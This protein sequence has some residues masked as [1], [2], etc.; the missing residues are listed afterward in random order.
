MSFSLPD[1]CSEKEPVD[2]QL[3]GVCLGRK[4]TERSGC[5][6]LNRFKHKFLIAGEKYKSFLSKK[7]HFNLQSL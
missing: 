2:Y 3:V 5:F 6:K 4:V 1:S 7:L